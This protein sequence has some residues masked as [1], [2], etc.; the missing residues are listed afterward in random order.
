MKYFIYF[1]EEDK[2]GMGRATEEGERR[3]RDPQTEEG[4]A[5]DVAANCQHS[6]AVGANCQHA[7]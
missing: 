6:L 7:C 4:K 3:G 2:G 1:S 5:G